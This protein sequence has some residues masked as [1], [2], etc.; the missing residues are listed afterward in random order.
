MSEEAVKEIK[1][2]KAPKN[3]K[4]VQSFLGFANFYRKF[5][6]LYSKICAP[7]MDLT[8]KGLPWKWIHRCEAAFKCLKERFTSTPILAHFHHEHQKH[9]ETDASDLAKGSILLQLKPDER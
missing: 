5:I 9:L 2:W 4:E 7:L 3:V 1:E 8:K 6:K